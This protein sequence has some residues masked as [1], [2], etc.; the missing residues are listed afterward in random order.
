MSWQAKN[1]MLVVS[2]SLAAAGVLACVAAVYDSLVPK[3]SL[4]AFLATMVPMGLLVAI[5]IVGFVWL[6]ERWESYSP[7]RREQPLKIHPPDFPTE[8]EQRRHFLEAIE[9]RRD[10][11]QFPRMTAA[12]NR[13]LGGVR[14]PAQP[15]TTSDQAL[16]L[17]R[18]W[19]GQ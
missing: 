13:Y 6:C 15:R 19:H 2:L 16:S 9:R 8:S 1:K 14:G 7:S 3:G 10:V 18:P 17:V 5:I 12:D 11:S 4:W